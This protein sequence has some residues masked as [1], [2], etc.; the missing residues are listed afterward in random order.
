MERPT[1]PPVKPGR[2]RAPLA[3]RSKTAGQVVYLIVGDLQEVH[4]LLVQWLG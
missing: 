1:A 4:V 3:L 2:R